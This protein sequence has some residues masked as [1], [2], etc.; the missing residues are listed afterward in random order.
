MGKDIRNIG[1][2]TEA[3]SRGGR[4]EIEMLEALLQEL[5]RDDGRQPEI[6][7]QVENQKLVGLVIVTKVMMKN[8]ARNPDVIF[9]DGTYKINKEGYCMFA[10]VCEDR[11]KLCRKI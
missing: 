2:V 1:Q 7:T 8:F 9:V 4:T 3:S 11:H 6:R 10:I 5:R